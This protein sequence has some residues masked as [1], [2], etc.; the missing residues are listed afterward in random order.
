MLEEIGTVS[1]KG[2]ESDPLELVIKRD[3]EEDLHQALARLSFRQRAVLI[4]YYFQGLTYREIAAVT[5]RPL[6]SIRADLHRG[7]EKLRKMIVKKWGLRDAE[8]RPKA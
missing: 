3:K 1:L 8:T 5:R 7:K 2:P 4:L 6:G